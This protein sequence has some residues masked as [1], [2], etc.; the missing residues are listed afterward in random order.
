MELPK[1][2]KK[3]KKMCRTALKY[4]YQQHDMGFVQQ[5]LSE[6]KTQKD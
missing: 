1:K 5:A 3:V 4:K 2:R 6:L